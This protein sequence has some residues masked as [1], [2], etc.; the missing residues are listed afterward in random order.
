V[1]LAY[2]PYAWA[3]ALIIIIK[4]EQLNL[5]TLV[6]RVTSVVSAEFDEI[7][8]MKMEETKIRLKKKILRT[9]M[10]KMEEKGNFYCHHST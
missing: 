7:K 5:R 2:H 4:G 8:H 10:R 3:N 1:S 9:I 6:S